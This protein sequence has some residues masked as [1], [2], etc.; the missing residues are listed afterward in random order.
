MGLLVP[1]GAVGP[2]GLMGLVVRMG[3]VSRVGLVGLVVLVVLVD[4]GLS[5]NSTG[6]EVTSSSLT[7]DLHSFISGEKLQRLSW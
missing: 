3:L 4:I 2:V 6:L 1:V 7:F 5:S